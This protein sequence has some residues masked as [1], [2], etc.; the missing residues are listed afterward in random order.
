[1]TAPTRSLIA[2]ATVAALFASQAHA[3]AVG[4]YRSPVLP[5]MTQGGSA[6]LAVLASRQYQGSDE[7]R[8]LL[9]PTFDYQWANGVFVGVGNGL[10]INWSRSPER[11]YGLR[12]TADFGRDDKRSVALA[13]MGDIRTRPEIGGFANFRVAD[14]WEVASSIRYGAGNDRKGL[15][16]DLGLNMSHAL[17]P[18]LRLNAGVAT[19]WA[20]RALTQSYFGVN[21]QQAANSGYAVFSPSAGL[22]DV[23]VGVA[24]NYTIAPNWSLT[25]GLSL[26]RLLGDAKDSP[27]VRDRSSISG[28]VSTSYRF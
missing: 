4:F 7:S 17:S 26:N 20:N 13:G 10:G 14:G 2:A 22:R 11:S 25:G 18:S 19:A 15:V 21:T 28:V 12:L 23:R 9:V 24:L 1:M 6:G 5:G 8:T 3:Q 27:I 16:V